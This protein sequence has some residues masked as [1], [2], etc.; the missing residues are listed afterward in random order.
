MINIFRLFVILVLTFLFSGCMSEKCEGSYDST[1]SSNLTFIGYEESDKQKSEYQK[2]IEKIGLSNLSNA[3]FVLRYDDTEKAYNVLNVFKLPDNGSFNGT[4]DYEN[5]EIFID[6]KFHFVNKVRILSF[7]FKYV[8]ENNPVI[9]ISTNIALKNVP[10]I[11]TIEK[12]GRLNIKIREND[13]V[14]I[15]LK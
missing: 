6:G 9:S 12:F 5:T 7:N 14:L 2:A 4:Y 1:L 8:A 15:Y 10:T 3:F 13:T 11:L